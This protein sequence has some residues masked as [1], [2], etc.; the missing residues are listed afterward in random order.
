[1]LEPGSF[2]G[3]GIGSG[4]QCVF[5]VDGCQCHGGSNV[6]GGN[7]V[8]WGSNVGWGSNA[9][10]GINVRRT[11]LDWLEEVERLDSS[12]LRSGTRLDWL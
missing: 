12:G 5:W 9:V 1:V 8:L 10:V 3:G 2:V 6:R 7:N 11:R 4:G